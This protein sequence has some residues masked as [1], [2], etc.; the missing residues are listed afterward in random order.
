MVKN[1]TLPKPFMWISGN[2]G[3]HHVHHLSS[4]IPFHQLPK[5]LRDFP[6]LQKAG[7]L[8]F[9]QSLK[10]IRLALWDEKERRLI[11]FRECDQLHPA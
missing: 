8:T 7:R 1:N 10:T 9:R 3:I 2:I 11:S 4:K 5:V 6:E